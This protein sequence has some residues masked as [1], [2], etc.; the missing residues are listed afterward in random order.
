MRYDAS[1]TY[2]LRSNL[3]GLGLGLALG[4]LYVAFADLGD[5]GLTVRLAA[6]AGL[7]LVF[8]I[9]EALRYYLLGMRAVTITDAGIRFHRRAGASGPYAWEGF[10]RIRPTRKGWIFDREGGRITL[11]DLGFRP[12][13]W[14]AL[15]AALHAAKATA[16]LEALPGARVEAHERLMPGGVERT[17]VLTFEPGK[18]GLWLMAVLGAVFLLALWAIVDTWPVEPLVV[19]AV[20]A[21]P[22]LMVFV[23]VQTPRRFVFYDHAFEVEYYAARPR[24]IRYD[25]VVDMSGLG[26]RTKQGRVGFGTNKRNDVIVRILE[27]RIPQGQLT[28]EIALETYQSLKTLGVTLLLMPLAAWLLYE[29][30]VPSAWYEAA[31]LGT[32][33]GLAAGVHWI[34]KLWRDDA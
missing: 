16:P 27:E 30:G 8:G 14:E 20:A 7:G 15:T 2:H 32:F 29:A 13:D 11:R 4:G 22:L 1:F 18:Q 19:I 21:L 6:V 12:D 31:L 5:L 10:E 9:Y 28:G 24:R 3:P 34:W 26:L 25:E 17:R 33:V 23:V